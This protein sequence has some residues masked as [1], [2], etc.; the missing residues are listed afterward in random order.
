MWLDR[1]VKRQRYLKSVG[2]A[3]DFVMSALAMS[4]AYVLFQHLQH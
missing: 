4:C 3:Q 2:N 1:Q